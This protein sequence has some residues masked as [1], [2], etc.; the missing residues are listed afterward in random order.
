[1]QT[2]ISTRSSTNKRVTS[3]R[4]DEA[5]QSSSPLETT[6][7][8]LDCGALK[9]YSAKKRKA[10]IITRRK[11]TSACSQ[12]TRQRGWFRER[13]I[14]KYRERKYS[15]I[16]LEHER[17]P[18]R[19]HPWRRPLPPKSL[20]LTKQHKKP[21]KLGWH[22]DRRK[23]NRNQ[24]LQALRGYVSAQRKWVTKWRQI[25]AE[26]RSGSFSNV[27]ICADIK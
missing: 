27:P 2:R 13:T 23:K 16:N 19:A 14:R 6:K 12:A 17:L 7:G 1:M 18:F 20:K 24:K 11:L 4:K 26:S 21:W 25:A 9:V 10:V 8:N 5:K 3:L 15:W 22:G